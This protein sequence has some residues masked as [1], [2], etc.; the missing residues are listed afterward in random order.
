[1][2]IRFIRE[3]NIKRWDCCFAAIM[4]LV[5]AMLFGF[6]TYLSIGNSIEA[7]LQNLAGK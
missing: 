7:L 1:M 2:L 6:F 5:F 4:M 3:A